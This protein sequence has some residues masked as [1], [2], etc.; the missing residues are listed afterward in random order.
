MAQPMTA[1]VLF[2]VPT[3][4][5]AAAL[6]R[7]L[8]AIA[9][10][11]WPAGSLGILVV[12]NSSTDDTEAVVADLARR[13]PCRI[14]YLRKAPEGPTVARNVGLRRATSGYVA[15]VDSDVEL[16]PGWTAATVAALEADPWLVQV[17]GKL[18]FAHDP[19][20]LN[21]YGGAIGRLGLAWDH[22]EGEP[23][24]SETA[25]RDVAWINTSAVLMRPGPTPACPRCWRRFRRRRRILGVP[26]RRRLA[27]A[28]GAG[29]PSSWKCEAR[30]IAVNSPSAIRIG[31]PAA[32]RSRSNAAASRHC[33][34][35]TGNFW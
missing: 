22:A 10:Q 2:V 15:L 20:I 16:D 4:N 19:A 6:P 13:L 28:R 3:F 21:G 9:R 7:T 12:D 30:A 35:R 5:R 18:M 14:D 17:G 31:S 23:A 33:S 34:L 11:R 1:S 24:A 32:T 29:P 8:G 25:P 27:G 26:N